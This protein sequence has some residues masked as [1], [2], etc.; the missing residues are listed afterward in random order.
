MTD[1]PPAQ[2]PHP[3]STRG[4]DPG[5][6]AAPMPA[7][8]APR[9]V[10]TRAVASMALCLAFDL[11]V[12]G[13]AMTGAILAL[14]PGA[15]IPAGALVPGATYA[16]LVAFLF[17][18]SGEHR[19]VWRYVGYIDIVRLVRTVLLAVLVFVAI[20]SFTPPSLLPGIQHGRGATVA[21]GAALGLLAM[22]LGRLAVRGATTGDLSAALRFQDVRLTPTVVFG[23]HEEV[24]AALRHARRS[25]E[26]VRFRP[27]AIVETDAVHQGR[28]IEGVPVAGGPNTLEHTLRQAQAREGRPPVLAVAA[29]PGARRLWEQA[30]TTAARLDVPVR[31]IA[32]AG[33]EASLE[34]VMPQDLLSRPPRRLDPER[35]RRLV[36]GRRVLITGAGGTIG[37]ELARQVAA[38]APARVLLLDA[39]ERAVY[40]IDLDLRE[41]GHGALV[42]PVIGDVRNREAMDEVFAAW[43]PE[44]VL[45]AAAFKHVPLMEANPVEAVRVNVGG[46]RIVAD[47]AVRH[48]AR[49]FVLISSDKAVNPTNVMG[50]TKR[51]GELIVEARAREAPQV[52]WASVRFGNVLGSSGSVVP[53]FER[54]IAA[55]GPV[56]VTDPAITRYFMTVEEATSLV[57]QAA[58]L[59]AEGHAL[60]V[61]DMGEPVRIV[62]LARQMIRLKGLEPE[63]DIPI[64]FTGL[65]P[66]EKLHEEIF[67]AHEDAVPSAIEGVRAVRTRRQGRGGSKGAARAAEAAARNDARTEARIEALT[68]AANQRDTPAVL[69]LLAELVPAFAPSE[70]RAP[71]LSQAMPARTA[72]ESRRTAPSLR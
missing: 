52:R 15:S 6:I 8:P 51:V 68:E 64:V 63:I 30:L 45:H 36:R 42:E 57:L 40:E 44:I 20:K 31:R 28:T 48:G 17:W 4:H 5:T 41:R 47:A 50:A 65:R 43:Q 13:G 70:A 67:H 53:L 59:E 11:V 7:A 69:G 9:T 3:V 54:Q 34:S 39:S 71:A 12:A 66:G 18:A 24:A 33:R 49:A 10:R 21:L 26:A 35:V 37:S 29:A 62:D 38:A 58:A 2:A 72:P 60:Y 23:P 61:L 56:T 46:V 19:A 55:G 22:V 1:G 16:A 14:T 25:D 32:T 27:V